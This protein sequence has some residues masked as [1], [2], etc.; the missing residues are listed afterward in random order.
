MPRW[1][2]IRFLLHLTEYPDVT[3]EEIKRFRELGSRTAGHPSTATLSK[4]KRPR[5][6]LAK[7]LP[8]RIQARCGPW[9]P[10]LEKGRRNQRESGAEKQSRKEAKSK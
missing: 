10:A 1:P 2:T 5:A 8:P 6:R 7:A 4:L 9:F 3:I